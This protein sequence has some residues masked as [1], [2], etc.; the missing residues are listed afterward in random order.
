MDVHG[1][2]VALLGGFVIA[3]VLMLSSIL[4]PASISAPLPQGTLTPTAYAYLPYVARQYPLPTTGFLTWPFPLGTHYTRNDYLGRDSVFDRNRALGI[5]EPYDPSIPEGCSGSVCV[6][7]NHTGIDIG[8][9]VGTAF[10]AA[11]PLQITGFET[12]PGQGGHQVGV[13]LVDYGNG[14]TGQYGHAQLL[15]GVSIGDFIQRGQSFGYV[16][17]SD[18]GASHLHFETQKTGTPVDPY[19]SVVN[20]TGISLWTVYND[21]QY[22]P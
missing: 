4:V 18:V 3:L 1:Y 5:V 16:E 22:A 17:P 12:R 14:Y 13:I 7:D 2:I 21:P 10:V 11:A 8:V 9:E 19:D 20:P 6:V 15:G